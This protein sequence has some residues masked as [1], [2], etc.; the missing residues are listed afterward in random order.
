MLV[1]KYRHGVLTKEVGEAV[2]DEIKKLRLWLEVL[3]LEGHGCK[4]HIHLRHS[5]KSQELI[6]KIGRAHV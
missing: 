2:R 1:P 6:V 5:S 3:I 4:D